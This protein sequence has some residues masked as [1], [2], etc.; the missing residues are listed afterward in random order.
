MTI[1]FFTVRVALLMLLI[2]L[3]HSYSNTHPRRALFR[4]AFLAATCAVAPLDSANAVLSSPPCAGGV[5]QGCE[6][7]SE[8]NE[9]IKSLQE[10]S[11]ENRAANAREGLNAYNM[12]NYPDYFQSIG[13]NLVKKSDG[14][15][16]LVV[17][18]AELDQL[19]KDNKIGL[20]KPKAKGGKYADVTQKPI[21]VLKE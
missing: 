21:L 11:A 13:K 17:T 7:R 20:E 15:G 3:A 6:E 1:S 5:G 2:T 12:K 4:S 10:K 16:F 8:G 14:S 18:D 9:F 19:K